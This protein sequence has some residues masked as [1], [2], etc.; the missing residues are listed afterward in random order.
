M[1]RALGC[2]ASAALVVAFLPGTASASDTY[3]SRPY[4]Q[5]VTVA[6]ILTT[7]KR[8]RTSPTRNGGHARGRLAGQH[9]DGRLRRQRR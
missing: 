1:R 3:N 7:S 8:C 4:R 5:K 6:N 2:V 9:A